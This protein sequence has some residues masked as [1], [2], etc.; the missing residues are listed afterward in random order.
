[1]DDRGRA[2][3]AFDFDGTITR[4]DTLGPFLTHYMGRRAMLR[5][6]LPH[7]HRLGAAAIGRADRDVA[8]ERYLVSLLA[9]RAADAL[10]AAGAEYAHRVLDRAD[11]N[12]E[13][14]DRMVW[15]AGLGHEIVV[16]SASL[17]VYVAPVVASLGAHAT[18]AT[19]VEVVDGRLTGRLT[20]GNVRAA[21]KVARLA[22]WLRG[23]PAEVWAYGDSAGDADLL[24]AA[25]H[26]HLV[27][28]GRI[29][30]QR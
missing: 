19:E 4:K 25:D 21:N 26:P 15:H 20:G 10:V 30:P 9:G 13:V 7:A 22:T 11:F 28:R 24:A 16:I 5:A 29:E 6:G 1:M 17:A 14:V 8:K 27:R 3:A 12:P 2:V 23:E 18:F